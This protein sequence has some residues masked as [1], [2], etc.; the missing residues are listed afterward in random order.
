MKILAALLALLISIPLMASES[1]VLYNADRDGEGVSVHINDGHL[2]MLFFTYRDEILF[3][4][5]IVSPSYPVAPDLSCENNPFWC[6]LTSHDFDG[7]TATGKVHAAMAHGYP[8]PVDR[9]LGNLVEIGTF[10]LVR[11][12]D[13]F[14][15]EID[16]VTN[17]LVTPYSYLYSATHRFR[18]VLSRAGPEY[19]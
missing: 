16:H 4:P 7:E 9:R 6:T 17:D 14:D 19:P 8:E 3:L 1:L 2:V 13:G 10:R 18:S 12:G 5:P 15:L 11:A